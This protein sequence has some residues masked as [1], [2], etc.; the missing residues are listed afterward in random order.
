MHRTEKLLH[1]F[2]IVEIGHFRELIFFQ[3]EKH[4]KLEDQ[5][6]WVVKRGKYFRQTFSW[7]ACKIIG[8]IISKYNNISIS[9][10]RPPYTVKLV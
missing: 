6:S 9:N 5:N 1:S 3:L 4:F 10:G 8:I 2:I 7:F